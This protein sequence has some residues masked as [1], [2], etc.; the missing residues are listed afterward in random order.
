M[1]ARP[2]TLLYGI[3]KWYLEHLKQVLNSV[4]YKKIKDRTETISFY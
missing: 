1:V 3:R 2:S 4:R